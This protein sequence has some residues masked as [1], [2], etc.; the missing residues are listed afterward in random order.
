MLIVIDWAMKF[1]QTRF[2]EKQSDWYDK[3][4]LSWHVSSVVSKGVSLDTVVV[5]SYVHLFDSSTQDWFSVASILENLLSTIK[6]SMANISKAYIRSDEAGCY[7]NNLL[8]A[9]LKDIGDRVGI[10]V[11]SYDFSEP[12]QGKDIF[13]RIICPLKS[14]IRRYCNE[15]HDILTAQDM[16]TALNCRPVKGTTSSVNE[17]K[18][19]VEQLS[20]QKITDFSCSY[21][22]FQYE[23]TGIR[24]W[25]AYGIGRGKK[26]SVEAIYIT[27]QES[28][29]LQVSV[30]FPAVQQTR[31]TKLKK[32]ESDD[33]NSYAES[34]GLFDCAEPGCNHVFETF[35]SLEFHM[36]LG[37]HSRFLN[38]ES[39]YDALKRVWAKQ[40]AT[41]SSKNLQSQGPKQHQT[42]ECRESSSKIGWVLS[43]PK[44]GSVRFSQNVRKYLT[45]KFDSGER[46]G[47]KSDPA[48]VSTDMRS[49]K[50][51]GG[52]KLFKTAEWLNKEQ[53]KGFF[54]RLAK[55][56]RK[57]V[58][59]TDIEKEIQVTN[60]ESDCDDA[61]ENEKRADLINLISNELNVAHPIYYDAYDLCELH[62]QDKL[63]GFKVPMLKE[64][65]SHFELG[66][67]S[68][69]KKQ[70]LINIISNMLDKCPCCSLPPKKNKQN[71][72][73]SAAAVKRLV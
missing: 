11:Q 73:K 56:R 24:V 51:D 6:S 34:A 39:V 66:F 55:K 57:G 64:I 70:D 35:E 63:S 60:C 4:G 30:D 21:H 38:S 48:Q 53:I 2:R 41:L 46:T 43:K 27:H 28:T 3:R 45:T 42:L 44:T 16:H 32:N 25:K 33:E 15:G 67:K 19:S 71:Y 9:S 17:V 61:E 29:K 62:K 69:D 18:A 12:Q 49:A 68:K 5:T 47:H 1:Q 7:H 36:D 54:S 58:I 72:F 23:E 10:C 13:D 31:E 50:D 20:V 14:S 52:E 59:S 8:I 37:Q 26:L 22:N 65:C 40:F